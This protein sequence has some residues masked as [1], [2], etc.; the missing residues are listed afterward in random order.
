MV[1]LGIAALVA[2]GVG[3]AL[4]LARGE[5]VSSIRLRPEPF[6]R[7]VTAEGNLQA[8]R[9]TPISAPND[10]DGP[11]KIAWIADDG[12]PLRKGDPIVRFDPTDLERQLETGRLDRKSAEQKIGQASA[13]ASATRTR[14]E[15]DLGVV[16]KELDAAADG[17]AAEGSEVFSRNERIERELDRG[18][19]KVRLDAAERQAKVEIELGNAEK[20]LAEIERKK[21]Q[22]Q[23]DRAEKGLSSL[24]VAAPHD[25]ILV[26][27]RDWRGEIRRVG[28]TV[29]PGFP[30][31]QIPDLATL[32]AEVYVLEADAG[33]LAAGQ[34]AAVTV[35]SRPG[36]PL[37][38]RVRRVEPLA[39]PRFRGSP[40][41]YFAATLDI[42]ATEKGLKPGQRIV[43][44]LDLEK[45]DRALV[46][47]RQA[48]FEEGG[49]SWVH[50]KEG[51]GFRRVRVR[52]GGT[53]FGRVRIQSGLLSGDE[54]ALANPE[55][56]EG[57][58]KTKGSTTPSPAAGAG[59]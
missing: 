7:R 20:G 57:E 31:A 14:R 27:G 15:A 36:R 3:S 19:A 5:R 30:L 42:A 24:V 47:P 39:K 38:G 33:G 26:L 25:G 10:A 29:W 53:S 9:S 12:A 21:A 17:A 13:E 18:L 35:E 2:V 51:N 46:L 52:I 55:A 44:T 16:R 37:A 50:R 43:A 8:V 40:V 49:K 41:Q 6:V 1:L 22:I 48:I 11:L 45:S 58:A 28:D 34:N 59:P 4:L 23:I 54:I 56:A 32:E